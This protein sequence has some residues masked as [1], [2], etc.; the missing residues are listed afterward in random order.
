M[1]NFKP[2]DTAENSAGYVAF[3]EAGNEIGKCAFTYNT[4]EMK[5]TSISGNNESVVEG[6]ARSAM[7]Y[8]ANR[9]VYLATV[10]AGMLSPAFIKLGF[11]ADELT[12]EIPEVLTST[13]C[14]CGS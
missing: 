3:D 13:C 1:I 14:G 7:N 9:G 8:C 10:T 6:L 4:L 5:F 11:S 12:R 2:V